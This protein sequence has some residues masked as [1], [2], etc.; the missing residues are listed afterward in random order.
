[1]P[2][3]R[4]FRALSFAFLALFAT[5]AASGAWAEEPMYPPTLVAPTEPL[6]P[7][8]QITKFHLPPGFEIQL[9]AHE[10]AINKPMN[11][12]FDA[13]GRM[14]VS[15]SLEYPFPATGDSPRRDRLQVFSEIDPVSGRAG[16]V[17]TFRDGLN[18]PIGVTPTA[19]GAIYYSIPSIHRCFD[20]D[21][22]GHA[23]RDE[24]LYKEFG[25]RDTH[26]MASSFTRWIDGWIYSCHGFANDSRV[27]G[28]DGQ[29]VAMQSGN[30]FR[31]RADGSHVEQFT[32]GQ[33]N[34]FGLAFDPLG[35]LFSA[36]CH[37]LPIYQLLR[38]AWYPSFGKPHDGLGFGPTMI[39]HDHGSTGICGVVYYAADHFPEEYRDTV[40]ICNPVTGRVNHDRLAIHGSTFQALEQ[41]DFLTCDDGWF[42]PVDIKLGPDGALYVLDFYNCIIGHYE[43]PLLHPRRDRERGRIWRIVHVGTDGKAP[44]P[45]RIANLD[46]LETPAL[47]GKLSSPNIT[48]RVLATESLV[49]RGPSPDYERALNR[50]LA[51]KGADAATVHLM[52]IVERTAKGGVPDETLKR[53]TGST[54]PMV[55]VHSIKLL[56]ERG[57]AA[58]AEWPWAEVVLEKLSDPDAFTRRASADA[59]G[60]RP[61]IERIEPLFAAWENAPAE[62]THLIH[63]IRMAIRDH[64][65]LPG[66]Y[67]RIAP[68]LA[69]GQDRAA[70][71]AGLTLGTRTAEG[72]AYLLDYVKN[73]TV[74]AAALPLE[75]LGDIV[76]DLARYLPESEVAAGEKAARKAAEGDQVRS[77]IA[78]FALARASQERGRP[79][80][81]GLIAWASETARESL[82]AM[83][84]GTVQGG[85]ELVRELKLAELRDSAANHA[86]AGAPFADLRPLAIDACVSCDAVGAVP[87]LRE[88]LAAGGEPL[89]LRQQAASALGA[90]QDEEVQAELLA[91]LKQ[92]PERLAIVIAAALASRAEGG[93][94]LLAAITAG[95][96][97]PQLLQ[98]GVVRDRLANARLP[99]LDERLAKL[100]A[101][102]PTAEARVRTL[103]DARR[104]AFQRASRDAVAG[105]RVFRK[106]CA[107]CHRVEG[108]GTKVGPDLD[109]IGARG[110]DR[111]LEDT[112]DPSRNVDQ[113]FRAT[114]LTTDKGLIV[115]GLA[116]REEGQI[117]VLID[118]QGK[119]VRVPLD[120]IDERAVTKLS[121]MPG[122]VADLAT[123][124]EFVDLLEYLLGLRKK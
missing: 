94:A 117:L 74:S 75:T 109:G 48:V 72:A 57:A 112:L 36:D 28:A 53:L 15:T 104:D 119:E 89:S 8:E 114:S 42:R 103:I 92:A 110:V 90:Q 62:D 93:E 12:N 41:P 7:E 23:D 19:D 56:A 122:N 24:V 105:E 84:Q 91:S 35:N 70:R 61:A 96:A 22:D 37:T 80:S 59:L 64:L 6:S 58:D 97:S 87:M 46:A 68:A 85:L 63:V 116:L 73:S 18:I 25:F 50:A 11:L 98:E 76:H 29:T 40:F 30:T 83:D 66:S 45:E 10:P 120:E 47:L 20:A 108:K 102:L 9:V 17:A 39:G 44:P 27:Q 88:I 118:A 99:D 106:H 81:E 1:M 38:G 121:P 52:W 101:D 26:G 51:A 43:V 16:K 32:H 69:R 49:A 21:G 13:A 123:E 115:S 86:A 3:D 67:E 31:M 60:R 14:Y 5:F 65:L 100:T 33:V 71:L 79:L 82:R 4:R 113:A 54:S 34:P 55:R 2:R 107:A 77:R 124:A 78:V 111:L 95:Q